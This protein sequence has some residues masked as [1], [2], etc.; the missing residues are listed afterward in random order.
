MVVGRFQ[1]CVKN[2][3]E[4][5]GQGRESREEAAGSSRGA[6]RSW[7]GGGTSQAFTL[8]KLRLEEA[9]ESVRLGSWG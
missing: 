1:L 6:M 4:E 8:M 5:K 7:G 3:Q 9:T 2:S